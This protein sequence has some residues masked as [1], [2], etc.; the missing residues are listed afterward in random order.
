MTAA[1]DRPE[2]LHSP[3]GGECRAFLRAHLD[4]PAPVVT[5]CE[6]CAAVH[7]FKSRMA[8]HLATRPTAPP[9]LFARPLL[10][11]TLER[12][13][14]KCDAGAIGASLRDREPTAAPRDWV[15]PALE[16]SV[17]R[18][19]LANQPRTS[20]DA[21]SQVRRAVLAE[22]HEVRVTRSRQ[23]WLL[24]MITAAAAAAIVVGVFMTQGTRI[25]A[26]IVFLDLDTAPGIDFSAVR[27]G[28]LR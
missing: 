24:G 8:A 14:A 25:E 27:Y 9:Q 1:S 17:L 18:A 10:E 16:S 5:H 3:L 22:A 12:V 23:R 15:A 19:A 7:A 2:G 28:A 20:P 4:A 13:V 21:W 6:R 11:A 26:N